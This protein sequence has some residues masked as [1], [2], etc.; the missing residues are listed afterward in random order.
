MVEFTDR[1]SVEAWCRGR[2]HDEVVAFGVLNAARVFPRIVN[3]TEWASSFS[4]LRNCRA[5][6]T[7]ATN[8]KFSGKEFWKATNSAA[9]GASAPSSKAVTALDKSPTLE[10][11][12]A[13]AASSA[14]A[15]SAYTALRPGDVDV[16]KRVVILDGSVGGSTATVGYEIASELATSIESSGALDAMTLPI[17]GETMPDAVLNDW[18]ILR[19]ERSKDLEIWGFWIDWYEGLL[20]GRAPDWELWREVVLIDEAVWQTGRE[21]VAEAI[22]GIKRKLAPPVLPPEVVTA[23]AR[24]LIAQPVTTK[25]I[26]GDAADRIEAAI[27]EYMKVADANALPDGLERLHGLPAI[28]R[29]MAASSQSAER[30][31]ELE[32]QIVQLVGEAL[33]LSRD[34]QG[35]RSEVAQQKGPTGWV[36]YREQAIKTSAI[37]SVGGAAATVVAAVSYLTGITGIE[38]AVERISDFAAWVAEETPQ[39]ENAVEQYRA[40]ENTPIDV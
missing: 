19:I 2:T 29:C 39:L 17:W 3:Y 31:L 24:R 37:L 16:A 40:A 34:V 32:A 14:A 12:F 13:K 8:I 33:G 35:L 21:A 18:E 28:L 4:D 36:I 10:N 7:A 6:L 27:S 23:Q 1:A 9:V 15:F 5:I 22:A 38:S 30:I 25:L 11:A 26:A 20:E